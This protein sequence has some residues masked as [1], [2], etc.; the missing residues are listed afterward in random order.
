M[1]MEV[2]I[3]VIW[4]HPSENVGSFLE[5]EKDQETDSPLN[6]SKDL[7]LSLILYFCPHNYKRINVCCKSL[8]VVICY[9]SNRKLIQDVCQIFMIFSVNFLLL[10]M[11]KTGQYLSISMLIC[12]IS[13]SAPHYK[14][15]GSIMVY[16]G[17]KR[18][19]QSGTWLPKILTRELMRWLKLIE[20]N[21]L[22][23]RKNGK[24]QEII[25]R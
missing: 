23:C 19:D 7:A 12:L 3:E 14:E 9:D 4:G 13:F 10:R 21:I 25:E 1:T 20:I 16:P 8:F 17:A 18:Q 2:E 6:S 11:G 15:A 24:N 22:V 5:T